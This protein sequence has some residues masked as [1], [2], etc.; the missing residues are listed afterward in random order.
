MVCTRRYKPMD[1]NIKDTEAP[2]STAFHNIIGSVV[3]Q[4]KRSLLYRIFAA[5]QVL[6]KMKNKSP[7]I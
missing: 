7:K 3:C 1:F 5:F 4:P 2:T 6:K